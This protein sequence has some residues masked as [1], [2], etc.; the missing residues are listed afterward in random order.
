[1]MQYYLA[2]HAMYHDW[3]YADEVG[4][5]PTNSPEAARIRMAGS[6]DGLATRVVTV[7]RK[8]IRLKIVYEFKT[9]SKGGF[10]KLRGKPQKTHLEQTH[11]YMK[12]LDAPIC[13]VI[14]IS[15]DDSNMAAFA[16]P[17]DWQTWIPIEERLR[18]IADMADSLH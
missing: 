1:M 18:K 5:D 4:F 16:Y 7:G 17:F 8:K 14:Y 3:E 12:C 13:I 2:S 11:S 15:K 9:I 6:T 10:Q